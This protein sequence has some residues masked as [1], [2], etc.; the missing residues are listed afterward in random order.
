V[1][2]VIATPSEE[3][4]AAHADTTVRAPVPAATAVPPASDREVGASAAAV[5][6]VAEVVVAEVVAEGADKA[7]IS[8]TE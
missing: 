4:R 3:V 7:M 2:P 1:V 6:V 8:R 5:V